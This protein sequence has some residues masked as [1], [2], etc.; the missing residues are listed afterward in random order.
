MMVMQCRFTW[1]GD[2]PAA[3]FD[4][5]VEQNGARLI[6]QTTCIADGIDKAHRGVLSPDSEF[7]F[8]HE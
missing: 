4:R 2:Y 1:P 5:D 7:G 6:I 8:S 3:L